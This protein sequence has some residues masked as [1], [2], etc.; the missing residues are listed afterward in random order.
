MYYRGDCSQEW[1]RFPHRIETLAERSS[2][3]R[4]LEELDKNG[5]P[6]HLGNILFNVSGN[7]RDTLGLTI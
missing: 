6:L 2:H 7:R 4:T 3:G 1:R 5:V